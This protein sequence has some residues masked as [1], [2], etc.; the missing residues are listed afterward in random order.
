VGDISGVVETQFGYHIIKLTDIR[1]PEDMKQMIKDGMIK[2]ECDKLMQQIS[3]DA[4]A[5]AK[6]NSK[7]V[8]AEQPKMNVK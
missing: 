6:F 8:S 4:C 1:K 3:A 5:K 2:E 7:L